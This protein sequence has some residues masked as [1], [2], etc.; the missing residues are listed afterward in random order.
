MLGN[1]IK[2]MICDIYLLIDSHQ[3]LLANNELFPPLI[4]NACLRQLMLVT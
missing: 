1:M 4:S 3:R 2:R